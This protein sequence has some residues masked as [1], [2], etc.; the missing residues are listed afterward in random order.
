MKIDKNSLL[1]NGILVLMAVLFLLVFAYGTSPLFIDNYGISD[2]AIFLLIGKGITAGYIPYVDLFDHKGPVMFFIEALGWSIWPNR[3]GNF[4]V[5][6]FFMGV[7]LILIFR[8]GRLFLA[9]K[10][11]WIPVVFFLLILAA[12]FEG[13]NLTEEYSLPLLF[14]PLYL[15]TKYFK[16]EPLGK[17]KHPPIYALVYGICFTLIL[18]IRL[19]NS[20]FIGAI[21]L[22]VMIQLLVNQSFRNFFDNA[23]T[24]LSG[25]FF[26]CSLVAIYFLANH[27]FG[28]MIYGTFLFN[29]K[30]AGGMSG[31]STPEEFVKFGY[32]ITPVIFSF[33]VGIYYLLK[34]VSKEIAW[35]LITGSLITFFSL[36]LGGVFY[37]Y[38]ILTA[39]CFV[40][41]IILLIEL[42]LK[43][44]KMLIQ[45][46]YRVMLVG[47]LALLL[48]TVASYLNFAD[49]TVWEMIEEQPNN[50]YYEDAMTIKNLIP[51]DDLDSVLGYSVPAGWFLKADITPCYK[52]FTMQE[53]WGRYDPQ[54][55]VDTNKRLENNPPK[56]IV[57]NNDPQQNQTLYAVLGKK[58]ELITKDTVISLYHLKSD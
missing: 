46:N 39:P 50:S 53:W 1:D 58:Y 12:T 45:E 30:Y 17:A 51:A 3:F 24:F 52:Y 38:F 14:L 55:L 8:M 34:K 13:G 18:F 20:V 32:A 23:L 35:L 21:V 10:W 57:L 11:C 16:L 2:S 48:I 47:V 37:H 40:L 36:L 42:Y 54:V 26:V 6:W 43:D 31:I 15:A 44:G 56:W 27:A 28:D 49:Q 29:L 22:V 9:K 7:N 25:S 41:A 33:S 19:N 5:Q 4:L